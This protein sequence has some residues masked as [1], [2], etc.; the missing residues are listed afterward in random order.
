MTSKLIF[1]IFGLFAVGAMAGTIDAF[2]RQETCYQ[3]DCNINTGECQGTL[4][5]CE[6]G[7]CLENPIICQWVGAAL[8]LLEN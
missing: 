2:K 7:Y 3:V 1:A 4:P 5:D 6:R 8:I